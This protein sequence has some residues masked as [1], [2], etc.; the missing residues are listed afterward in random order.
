MTR[1]WLIV[2]GDFIAFWLSLFMILTLRFGDI[3]NSV[4]AKGHIAPFTILY[5]CWT[6]VFY[7]FGLYDLFT[8]KPTIPHLRRF[9]LAL[10][11]SFIVGILLF[12]LA[13]IFGIS[14]KTNLVFQVISFGTLSFLSR[15]V[16]YNLYS[17]QITRPTI[18]VGKKI[19]LD[20]IYKAIKIN[21]QMGL[22]II[23][24][25]QDLLESLESYSH[26]ENAVFIIDIDSNRISTDDMV[27]LYK[28]NIDIIDIALAFE[29][30]LF[31]IPVNYISQPWIIENIN[32]KKNVLYAFTQR[33]FDIIFS[34]IILI[35]FLPFLVIC[36]IFIYVH[37]KGPIFYFQERVGLNGNVFKLYKLRSMI[38]NS[39]L[40]GA[41]WSDKNDPRIT[42]VGRIIRKLHLDEIPQM[43]NI[44]KGDI[45]LIGPRPERPEFVTKLEESI[46]HYRLRHI[47]HPGFTG[48]AQ[49]KYHY[50]NTT[51]D[52]KEKFEYDLYYIKNRNTFLDFG[53]FLRTLQI[54][55]TH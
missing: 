27:N 53:I 15:R 45:T 21:P 28:N 17:R 41:V 29:R 24:Y 44:L 19:Y 12:Y 16:F 5:L 40:N 33:S 48:W 26:L 55:F 3:S 36:A 30:Y 11:S 46:P 8:I 50:A 35:I 47:I 14:P 23:S 52:S 39:E 31:K 9:G 25:T 4:V 22:N 38:V 10:I 7:L 32:I 1:I 49:I 6:L 51:E 34:L 18:L 42:P 37:D 20:E 54:I 2:L 13:P 43:I